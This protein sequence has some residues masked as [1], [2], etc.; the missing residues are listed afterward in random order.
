MAEYIGQLLFITLLFMDRDAVVYK[1]VSK[2]ARKN[3][4]A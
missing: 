4:R 3:E 2:N 1:K